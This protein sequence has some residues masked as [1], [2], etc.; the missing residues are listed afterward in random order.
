MELFFFTFLFPIFC[1]SVI[2]RVVSIIIIIIIII[3]IPLVPFIKYES[4]FMLFF[5]F[6]IPNH[7]LEGALH[8]PVW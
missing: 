1:H 3:I 5:F 2:Y 4:F 7:W 6:C 8:L